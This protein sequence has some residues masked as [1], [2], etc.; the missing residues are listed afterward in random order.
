[1]QL[2]NNITNSINPKKFVKQMATMQDT[3]SDICK[4]V[5]TWIKTAVDD[6]AIDIQEIT[7]RDFICI[8]LDTNLY[9]NPQLVSNAFTL[10]VRYYT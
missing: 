9:E 7:H 6:K 4:E 8:L 3:V 10:L 5:N 2:Y 1:M